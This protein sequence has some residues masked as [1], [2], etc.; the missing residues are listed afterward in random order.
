RV[1]LQQHPHVVDAGVAGVAQREV[2]EPVGAPEAHRGLRAV[3]GEDAEA[4]AGPAGEDDD[5][6]AWRRHER[7]LS[8]D[9]RGDPQGARDL[10]QPEKSDADIARTPARRRTVPGMYRRAPGS[11][12]PRTIRSRALLQEALVEIV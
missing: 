11:A 6:R 1:V 7:F 10:P 3:L 5:E 4:R 8:R 2:D 9:D 12:D